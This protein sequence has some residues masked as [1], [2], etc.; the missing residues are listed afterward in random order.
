MSLKN[1]LSD[2]YMSLSH[3]DIHSISF[4]QPY[5][6]HKLER[7]HIKP[8]SS[9]TQNHYFLYSEPKK[10]ISKFMKFKNEV[11]SY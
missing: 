9:F 3:Y 11:H 6:S 7:R 10:D 2:K 8:H 4:I 1:L 5:Q